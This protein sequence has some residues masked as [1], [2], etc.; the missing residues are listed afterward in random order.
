MKT[1]PKPADRVAW[2][3]ARHSYLTASDVATL[4]SA[5]P[6]RTLADVA[7]D[8]LGPPPRED[9]EPT[10][11]MDR[12]NRLEPV[13]LD[14]FGDQHG[15]KVITPD[16]L[17]VNGRLLA[18]LDGEIVGNDDELVEAKS[19]S[20]RWEEPPEHVRWQIVAQCAASG[21]RA[22]WCVWL[23]S[24]MRLQEQLI[25]PDPAEIADV[26][27]RSAA[28]MAFIDLGMTPEGV[29][30]RAEH[31]AAMYPEPD[32]GST[33]ELDNLGFC[34]V[35]AW[36]Q[37]R[38]VRLAAEKAEADAKDVVARLLLDHEGAR[39]DGRLVATWKAVAR[40]SLDTKAL[41]AA[42]PDLVEKFTRAVSVRTL[43]ATG[44]LGG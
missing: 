20:Q 24:S 44:E 15:V 1:I 31:I 14:W 13:L 28:F 3:Q 41:K 27:E 9:N 19:T 11:A 22:G 43:R 38:Q 18:T 10:D 29:E 35:V 4:Y 25:V 42:E 32:E 6:Y 8:K 2:L 40:Q 23:D 30:L 12:G 37:C 26:L 21:R 17:Y 34:E 39:Y 5:H 36:E 16:V 7:V 33:V